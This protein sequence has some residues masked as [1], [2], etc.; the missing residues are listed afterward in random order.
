MKNKDFEKLL[1]YFP[2]DNNNC[3]FLKERIES[4]IKCEKMADRFKEGEIVNWIT[5]GTQKVKLLRREKRNNKD[6]FVFKRL[7]DGMVDYEWA[8]GFEKIKKYKIYK[9]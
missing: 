6:G 4:R 5:F 1:K 3:L 7:A 9:I 2:P 8:G